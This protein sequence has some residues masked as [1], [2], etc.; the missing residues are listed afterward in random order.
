[1]IIFEQIRKN[2]SPLLINNYIFLPFISCFRD[3][4]TSNSC[5]SLR[6]TTTTIPTE[7]VATAT[8]ATTATTATTS[9][10]NMELKIMNGWA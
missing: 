7:R 2:I 9:K 6:P 4:T 3:I 5:L 10:Q 1:M 8:R